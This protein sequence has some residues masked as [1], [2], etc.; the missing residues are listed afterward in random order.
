MLPTL[1]LALKRNEELEPSEHPH[2]FVIG[3]AADAFGALKAGNVAWGQA[4]FAC[5]NI[6]RLINGKDEP[7]EQYSPPPIGIKVSLG[8]V[9]LSLLTLCPNS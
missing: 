4:E 7:L 2:I 1:Q 6:L 8:L 3:D 9:R 5:R